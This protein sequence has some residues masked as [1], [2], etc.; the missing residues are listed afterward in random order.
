VRDVISPTCHILTG[1][2]GLEETSGTG[3][4]T[5]A[6]NIIFYLYKINLF[7]LFLNHLI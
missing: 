6:V 2:G 7:Y 4:A 5:V 1:G 3:E